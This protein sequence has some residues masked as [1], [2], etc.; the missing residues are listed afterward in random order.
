[1]LAITIPAVLFADRW[2]RR[3]S[4]LA[5]GI[6]LTLTMLLIGSLYAANTV[7]AYGPARWIVV[8]SI[9][10][11]ALSYCATWGPTAK[12]YAAELQPARTRA[13][14]TAVAQCSNFFANW[15]V[16]FV[17]PALL[18]R[19]CAAYFVFGGASFLA[20]G[21]VWMWAPETVGTVLGSVRD[22]RADVEKDLEAV[23][24]KT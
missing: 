20:V 4:L 1:M 16:A 14:G 13:V 22:G 21:V 19:G 6:L 2:G 12:V 15:L 23:S 8:V 7:H 5:G 9:F 11:F 3:T 17:A 10:V 18:R 24:S